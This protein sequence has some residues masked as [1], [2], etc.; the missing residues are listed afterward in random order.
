MKILFDQNLSSKLVDRLKDLYPDS[1]HLS[2]VGL[3]SATDFQV[4]DFAKEH[5]FAI[6]SK[7]SDLGEIGMVRGFPPRIIWIRRGNC[8]TTEIEQLLRENSASILNLEESA[9]FGILLLS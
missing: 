3:E 5:G 4:W 1:K 9:P 7:D 8:S 6:A 2:E